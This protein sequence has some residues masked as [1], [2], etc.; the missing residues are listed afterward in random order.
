MDIFNM[1]VG[2]EYEER[3]IN[4]QVGE[5]STR[6]GKSQTYVHM[7]DNA[8]HIKTLVVDNP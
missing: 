6:I 3:P 8:V 4:E 2:E 5:C 7:T 1:D